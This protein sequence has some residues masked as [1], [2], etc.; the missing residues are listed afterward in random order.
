MPTK[1]APP[2]NAIPPGDEAPAQG[3]GARRHS[4]CSGRCCCVL[5]QEPSAFCV[6]VD[7]FD[8]WVKLIVSLSES[9]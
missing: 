6:P 4:V 1:E 5:E 7:A 3:S 9:F 2:P 8:S